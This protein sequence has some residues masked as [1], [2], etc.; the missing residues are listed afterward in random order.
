[1]IPQTLPR[2][3]LLTWPALDAAGLDAA[4]TERAGGVS[5]GPYESLNLSLSVGDHPANVLENRRR[6]AAA[7]T[8]EPDDFVFAR[9]VHGAGV[10]VIGD[11]DR[12]SGT[13]TLD[14]AIPDTDALVTT[15]PGIILAILTADCVPIVLHDAEAGVLACVHSGWRGTVA[16]I[17]AAAVTVMTGLGARPHRIVAGIGPAIDPARYQVGPDVHG[18]VTRAF[19]KTD[20]LLRKDPT[21]PERWLLDLWAANR[22]VLRD[23]GVLEENIHVTDIPTGNAFFSDRAQRPCG[24]LALVARLR[25]PEQAR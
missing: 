14:D 9:Q 6:L 3:R 19:G 17:G 25:R 22:R 7:L 15:T 2:P 13:R 12:G 20:A 8:A 16:R 21:A 1:M 18:A 11:A 24:R 23:A 10:R 5:A 4:V